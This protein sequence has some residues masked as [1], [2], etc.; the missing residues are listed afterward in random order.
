MAEKTR[1][2]SAKSLKPLVRL[3][4]YLRRYARQIAIALSAL[5][6]ASVATLLV[7]IAVRRIIDHGFTTSNATLVNQYFAVMIGVVLLLAV[8]SA[9]RFYYV[10]WLG[11]KI[12]ADVRDTLFEHLL[13]LSP[14]FYESQ[15]TGEVVSRLTADTT[16]IKSAFS[17]TASIALRNGVMLIG[18]IAMMIFTS[19][20]LAGLAG[21]AIPLIVLPLVI[22]GRR[23]RV[24][25][26]AA[27]D[28]L[29][30][31]AAF[32][33]ER[34][35]AI[36]TVQSNVQE[37]HTNREF[38]NATRFAFLAAAKR[39]LARA[40]LTAAIIFVALGSIV[41]LLWFGA[42][43]VISGSLSGGTLSQFVIYAVIAAS[44]LGQLSEVW[45]EIQLAAGAAERISELLDETPQISPPPNPV[46]F[47]A[48]PRGAVKFSD[49]SFHY[50]TRTN[51]A[52]LN[53][54]N[55]TARPGEV[56]AVVGPSGA[57]KTTL[58]ALI[59]RFY[60]PNS[61]KISIDDVDIKT[62][63]PREL[64]KH[65]AVVPQD[66]I[67]FSGTVLD[68]IRFGSP[69]AT[70]EAAM[71]AAIAARVDE[72]AEKLPNGFDTEVGE[73]G[74]TL[75]GGQRQR[76]AIARAILRNAP[77]L[78]LDEATSSLDAESE[79]LIQEALEKLTANRTTLVVAHRL[80]TV[81]NADRILVFDGGKLVAQGTHSQLVKKNALY[82]RLAKLQ[83]NAPST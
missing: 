4:P 28:R 61:G 73:R 57:G 66:T 47:P 21:L 54:I 6:I 70:R 19:P 71:A 12:V 14:G 13:K 62:T 58:F 32:A 36:T 41:G 22:Y 29:A 11:E 10:M 76:I 80:A 77:I 7:P 45:G 63:D 56:T 30:A 40:V 49:V 68:N 38:G 81:R 83:F 51:T 27:Q 59:Q 17:S 44:S 3:T 26:R 20:K 46:A 24:L 60:D 72:F 52:A 82:A 53:N 67:I 1:S 43:E 15:K 8:S 79:A 64:R 39:T 65:I 18:A 42:Q 31:S 78:L 48:A 2:E 5:I 9:I 50:P 33:Q 69:D 23:V 37:I 35:S 74:I 25:S 75:S 16:Q 55:F 34:L